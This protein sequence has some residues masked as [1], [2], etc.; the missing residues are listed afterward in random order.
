MANNCGA[1]VTEEVNIIFYWKSQESCQANECRIRI[2]WL[3]EVE[4]VVLASNFAVSSGETIADITPEIIYFVCYN[5]DLLPHKVMLVEHYSFGNLS[6]ENI[7]FHV[8]YANNE[9]RIYEISRN[10]LTRLINKQI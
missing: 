2:Y 6:D 3:N 4:V 5:F 7:Y 10:K 9:A 1:S 8:L